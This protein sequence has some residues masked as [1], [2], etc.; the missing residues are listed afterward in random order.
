MAKY[1][2]EELRKAKAGATEAVV[3]QQRKLGVPNPGGRN[4]DEFVRPIIEKMARQEKQ[5]DAPVEDEPEVLSAPVG[6]DKEHVGTYDWNLRNDTYKAAPGSWQPTK[7]DRLHAIVA[8]LLQ[9]PDF[10]H[11]I[12]AARGICDKHVIG[13]P[14][15]GCTLCE[16]RESA[17]NEI[18]GKAFKRFGNPMQRRD[19]RIIVGGR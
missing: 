18:M 3:D 7:R 1:T 15:N 10:K 12:L 4:V 17:L 13:H 19:P 16:R 2:E 9:H 14:V 5:P 8:R 11:L 6:L